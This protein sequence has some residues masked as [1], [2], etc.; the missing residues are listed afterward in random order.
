MTGRGH[1]AASVVG[2]AA[3]RLGS[4]RARHRGS[5]RRRRPGGSFTQITISLM[6]WYQLMALGAL[7]IEAALTVAGQVSPPRPSARRHTT[8]LL[9]CRRQTLTHTR[10]ALLHAPAENL[11]WQSRAEFKMLGH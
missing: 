1:G 8:S 2:D 5:L 6:F 11:Q 7:G 9:G 10:R 4:W 3:A